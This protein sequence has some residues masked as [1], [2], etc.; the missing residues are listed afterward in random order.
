MNSNNFY[1]LK[2]L[3]YKNKYISLKNKNPKNNQEGGLTKSSGRFLFFIDKDVYDDQEYA[4]TSEHIRGSYRQIIGNKIIATNKKPNFL[5]RE[6]EKKLTWD[7][8]YKISLL[9]IP[10]TIEDNNTRMIKPPSNWILPTQDSS[11]TKECPNLKDKQITNGMI[12]KDLFLLANECLANLTATNIF[13]VDVN[14]Q[15]IFPNEII[16]F[17]E[18]GVETEQFLVYIDEQKAKEQEYKLMTYALKLRIVKE[19]KVLSFN[20]IK[21]ISLLVIPYYIPSILVTESPPSKWIFPG[22]RCT[23]LNEKVVTTGMRVKDYF[24][25]VKDCFTSAPKSIWWLQ[26]SKDGNVLAHNKFVV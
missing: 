10:F 12:F 9:I 24:E 20:E 6:T 11:N 26:V 7:D 17:G 1:K 14:V 13:W 25:L 16:E 21:S 19:S 5:K 8:L 22:T 18:F 2:Y 4:I 23:N 15:Q 3:K